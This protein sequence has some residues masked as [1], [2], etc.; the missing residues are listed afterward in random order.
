M[1]IALGLIVLVAVV[2]LAAYAL[3]GRGSPPGSASP[4]T[5][6]EGRAAM[7]QLADVGFHIAPEEVLASRQSL[8]DAHP[9]SAFLVR[10]TPQIAQELE[11][12][13]RAGGRDRSDDPAAIA[14]RLTGM[15]G[16]VPRP[17][18][19][20]AVRPRWHCL[21]NTAERSLQIVPLDD[22]TWLIVVERLRGAGPPARG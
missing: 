8:H 7:I 21:W 18:L 12:F 14:P 10:S 13:S 17:W 5:P 22:Q 3:I 9:V 2:A 19:T 16:L 4:L 6:D 1:K 20:N 11:A 15:E